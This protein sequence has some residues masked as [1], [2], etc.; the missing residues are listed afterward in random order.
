[1]LSLAFSHDDQYLVSG[2]NNIRTRKTIQVWKLS[3]NE[4]VQ[5]VETTGRFGA[6]LSMAFSPDGTSLAAC[7]GWDLLILNVNDK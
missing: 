1:M 3:T 2:N 6:P 4:L 5:Q 7:G